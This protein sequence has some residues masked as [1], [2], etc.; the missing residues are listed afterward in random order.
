M[1]DL[2]TFPPIF[3]ISSQLCIYPFIISAETAE[4]RIR[5]RTKIRLKSLRKENGPDPSPEIRGNIGVMGLLKRVK[6]K[7]VRK[8]EDTK[9]RRNDIV[10]N[11]VIVTRIRRKTERIGIDPS[12]STLLF[13]QSSVIVIRVEISL[14]MFVNY[15]AGI[16]IRKLG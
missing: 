16:V 6:S 1:S 13:V 9:K 8:S 15:F 5:T 12:K 10:A 3:K 2:E 7:L 11:L 4:I 14:L